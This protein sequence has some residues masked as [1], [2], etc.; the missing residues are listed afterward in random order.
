VPLY[1]Y[2]CKKCRRRSERIEKVAGPHLRK[3]PHC[4]GPVERL[5]A[6]PAVQFKGSGW[7]ATDYAGKGASA[8]A[9][10][11]GKAGSETPPASADSKPADSATT[12]KD[13]GKPAK[14]K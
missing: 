7:Y 1:E 10:G 8:A 13:K 6:A 2:E 3:C 4:G 14:K 11:P 9:E 5:L 12:E